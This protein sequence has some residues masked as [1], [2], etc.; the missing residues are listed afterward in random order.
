MDSRMF[1]LG[2]ILSITGERLVSP[3]GIDGVY[4][5][6]SFMTGHNLFTHQLPG[7]GR[8]CKPVLLNQ[9]PQLRDVDDSG[10]NAENWKAWL[11]KQKEQFGDELLVDS[12]LIQPP[13]KP[14][15]ELV[16]MVGLER[17]I[18]VGVDDG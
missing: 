12:L 8:D 15:Q 13:H 1:D 7:A 6:L 9:H 10:V 11:V 16:D 2:D 17:V 3:T 4:K 18:V 14:L 5:I